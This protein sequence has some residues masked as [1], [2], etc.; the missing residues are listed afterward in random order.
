MRSIE[1]QTVD[2][3]LK[4]GERLPPE[5]DPADRLAVSRTVLREAVRIMVTKGLL[6]TRHGVGTTVR[7]VTHEEVAAAPGG[8]A[9]S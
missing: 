3:N 8:R 4:V 6:E 1:G 2:G 5:R 9:S 7:E